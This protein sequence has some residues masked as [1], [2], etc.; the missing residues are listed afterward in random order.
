MFWPGSEVEI[1]GVRP[2]HWKPFDDNFPNRQRVQQVLDWL[3]LP[4]RERPS[5]ITLY[6]SDV[7][8]AGHTFGPESPEVL[9]VRPGLT[10]RSA[11]WLTG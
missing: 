6:F 7:D 10:R 8:T 9:D 3:A 4:E 11:R 5:F 1:G 2:A